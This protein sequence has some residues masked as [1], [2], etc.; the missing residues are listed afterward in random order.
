MDDT[1]ILVMDFRVV[2]TNYEISTE[3]K[4]GVTKNQ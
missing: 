2:R 3:R 4:A 1:R